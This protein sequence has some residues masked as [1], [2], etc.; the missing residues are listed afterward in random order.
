MIALLVMTDGRRDCIALTVPSFLSTVDYM[1]AVS[2]LWIH[3]DSG[4]PEYRA[5]LL[6]RF[7]ESE[8]WRII[9][10]AGRSGFGGAIRSA[11]SA[12][13]LHSR[14]RYVFHL[15]DDFTFSRTIPLRDMTDVLDR[16]PDLV[17]LALRRQPWSAEECA[18]GGIVEQHPDDYLEKRWSNIGDRDTVAWLEHRRF[19]TTNPGLYRM[20][21]IRSTEW[22]EGANSEGRFGISLLHEDPR[23][24]FG[25]IGSR[26]SGEWV[27]HIGVERVGSGY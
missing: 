3:D 15:E 24:R 27:E 21:L 22:P 2:E 23:R 9:S 6:E 8:G 25:F 5:W 4:D 13:R 20:E 26:D 11:W 1:P 18:A 10:T 17:N 7:P 19:F 16:Q 14:A 12:L